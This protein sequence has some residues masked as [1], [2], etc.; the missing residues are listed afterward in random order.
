VRRWPRQPLDLR[1]EKDLAQRLDA[2]LRDLGFHVSTTSQ[3]RASRQTIGMPDRWI[4]HP[5]WRLYAWLEYKRPQGGIVSQDQTAWHAIATA[6]G[7]PCFV[8]ANATDLVL[9]LRA[10]GAPI[11]D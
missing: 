9:A 5:R 10:L 8:V 3:L 4:M 1:L 2:D 11:Q 7:V 6:A